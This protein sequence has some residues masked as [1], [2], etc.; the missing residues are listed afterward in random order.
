MPTRIIQLTEDAQVAQLKRTHEH[1]KDG[2]KNAQETI[3]FLDTKTSILT[4][5]LTLTVALPVYVFKWMAEMDTARV[6][7][8]HQ[9]KVWHPILLAIGALG[10]IVGMIVGLWGVR[11][12][13]KSIRPR[14]P[15]SVS[16]DTTVL[17]P[18]YAEAEGALVEKYFDK[19]A[20]GMQW[21]EII[22]EYRDQQLEVGRILNRKIFHNERSAHW[23][24]RQIEIYV[25]TLFLLGCL[26][27]L[28]RAFHF[29]CHH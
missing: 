19:C 9:L 28:G 16:K 14:G 12:G 7:S 29:I 17:F 21:S 27:G 1:F 26:Y 24:W 23:F 5:L 25:A 20:K 6:L 13:I 2:Y 22:E 18:H 4:G 11:H 10:L 3:R 8:L 15:K